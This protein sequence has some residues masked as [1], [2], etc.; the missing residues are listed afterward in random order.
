MIYSLE[1]IL[2]AS[3]KVPH[4]CYPLL[5]KGGILVIGAPAK[6]RKS[7]FAMQL[8]YCISAGKTFLGE[9]EIQKPYKV[10]YIEKE[11]GI[12][13][14]RERIELQD[15]YYE[16]DRDAKQNLAFLPK[17]GK[18]SRGLFLGSPALSGI[19]EKHDPDVLVLDP[20][21][22]FHRADEDKSGDM[23][24]VFDEIEALQEV[25]RDEDNR[26]SVI[27]VHHCG[28]PSE[29]RDQEDPVALRGSSFIFDAGDSYV[30]LGKKDK[31]SRKY[32][33]SFTFRHTPDKETMQ[34]E[35]L[36]EENSQNGKW[37]VFVNKRKSD[38]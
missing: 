20:L 11:I 35:F 18:E 37:G 7:F 10:L 2:T 34:A 6:M 30:M 15:K 24:Q 8:A 27:L 36:T 17:G 5:S 22:R 9:F 1:K 19:I 38:D 32:Y 33:F 16:R 21:R 3:Q 31:K 28:K 25:G 4:V 12:P 14:V 29:F 13:G 26:R 23:E